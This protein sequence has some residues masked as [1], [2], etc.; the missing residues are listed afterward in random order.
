MGCSPDD[1]FCKSGS[2]AVAHLGDWTHLE[3][4]KVYGFYS[5]DSP[6]ATIWALPDLGLLTTRE[7]PTHWHLAC[8]G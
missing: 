3:S 2:E 4:G 7:L 1:R 5:E 8:A 6:S